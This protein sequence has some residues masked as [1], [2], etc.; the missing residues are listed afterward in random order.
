MKNSTVTDNIR[1]GLVLKTAQ[2]LLKPNNT[3]TTLEIKNDLRLSNK[4]IKWNQDF[5]SEAMDSFSGMGIFNYV[6][7]GT[8]RTYSDPT[9]PVTKAI[10]SVPAKVVTKTP[11][12]SRKGGISTKD[13]LKLMQES[14]G[15]FFTVTFDKKS[16]GS[17][18]ILNCQYI[19]GQ[20]ITGNLVKV[21]EA[22]LLLKK[23]PNPVRSF[24]LN[25]LKKVSISGKVFN[26]K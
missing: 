10:V 21:K 5:I 20:K 4:A 7:N 25:T 19:S 18:R 23:D 26:V 13:A 16:T 24:D 8:Y 2:R 17:E 6:S 1:K 22:S 11:T 15:R 12:R 3:V 9:R 14:K